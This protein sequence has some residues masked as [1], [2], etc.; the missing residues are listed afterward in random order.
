[1]TLDQLTKDKKY[2][3]KFWAKPHHL[4]FR[5][6]MMENI[7]VAEKTG[8][9]SCFVSPKGF[10]EDDKEKLSAYRDSARKEGYEISPYHFNKDAHT[11]TAKIKK[12]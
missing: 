7:R 10:T 3:K 4:R 8:K 1:M 11:A 6:A 9:F 5:E 12:K 2:S